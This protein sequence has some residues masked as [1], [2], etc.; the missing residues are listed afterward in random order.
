MVFLSNNM[1][2]LTVIDDKD[3]LRCFD[4]RYFDFDFDKPY[5]EFVSDM[6]ACGEIHSVS[7]G[8]CESGDTKLLCSTHLFALPWKIADVFQCCFCPVLISL[9]WNKQ[10]SWAIC[11]RRQSGTSLIDPLKTRVRW[12]EPFST[13]CGG[14][15]RV[16]LIKEFKQ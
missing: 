3:S 4:F 2:S 5:Q 10:G 9:S 11:R 14:D 16:T 8:P 6:K 12:T 7:P 1:I 13:F 15:H